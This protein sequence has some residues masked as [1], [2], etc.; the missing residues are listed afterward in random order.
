MKK[1][2]HRKREPINLFSRYKIEQVHHAQKNMPHLQS[3][4][5]EDN[6]ASDMY[7]NYGKNLLRKNTS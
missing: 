2:F 5:T 7:S 6:K 3:S 1:K 4:I